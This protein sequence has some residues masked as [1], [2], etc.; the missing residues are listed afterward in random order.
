MHVDTLDGVVGRPIV[1]ANVESDT[2]GA[3]ALQEDESR[4]VGGGF[5]TSPQMAACNVVASQSRMSFTCYF[6]K[7]R[8]RL[9]NALQSLCDQ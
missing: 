5:K 8:P 6:A 4:C 7:P 3:D 9:W 1:N 2:V